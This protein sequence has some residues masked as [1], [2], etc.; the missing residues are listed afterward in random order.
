MNR[1]RRPGLGGN[2]NDR[3]SGGW[4]AWLFQNLFALAIIGGVIYYFLW[5]ALGPRQARIGPQAAGEHTAPPSAEAVELATTASINRQQLLAAKLKQRQAIAAFDE[6]SRNLGDWEKEI[7]AWESQGPPLLRSDDGKRLAADTTLVKQFRAVLKE[8]RPGRDAV[9]AARSQAEEII[10]P[11]R[12]SLS[13]A[14]DASPPSDFAV[15]TLREAQSQA[16]NARERYRQAREAVSILLAQAPPAGGATPAGPKTLEQAIAD[17]DKAES[18]ERVATIEAAEKKAREEATQ[19]VAQEKAKVI[20]AEAEAEAQRLRDEAAQKKQ[21]SELA[22]AKS[23]EEME[24]RQK[25]AIAPVPRILRDFWPFL[26]SNPAEF[27]FQN[28]LL[29]K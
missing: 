3:G 15:T 21:A 7:A 13:N 22:A 18:L 29:C 27:D 8:E 23:V 28:S 17:L 6:L 4:L 20:Q 5:P 11:V 25:G 1:P 9:R 19:L 12:E 2:R 16:R 26:C 24:L 10:F 14:E